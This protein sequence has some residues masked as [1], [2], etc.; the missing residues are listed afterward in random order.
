MVCFCLRVKQ[1]CVCLYEAQLRGRSGCRGGLR[2]CLNMESWFG[3][4]T[5]MERDQV[6]VGTARMG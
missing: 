6:S 5:R 3:C 1:G 4:C 2:G